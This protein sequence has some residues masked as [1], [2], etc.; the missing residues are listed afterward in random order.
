MSNK[1]VPIKYTSRD[2]TS[3]KQDLLEYAKRYYPETFQ[4]FSEAGFGALMLDTVAY[5]GDILSFYLDYQANESMMDTAIE[6]NNV[7]RHSKNNGFRFKANPS[8]SGIVELYCIVPANS[9]G[10]GPNSDYLPIL[11]QG[12][13]FSSEDGTSFLLMEDI[14]FDSSDAENVVARVNESTG[15][16]TYY[17]IR[18]YGKVISGRF[19]EQRIVVGSYQEFKRIKLTE[20]SLAE[21][22]SVFDS[23]GHEY[24]EVDYLSQNTVY[25]DVI[26]RGNDKDNV[27]N[28]LKPIIVPRRFVVE[29]EGDA[30]YLQFGYGSDSELQDASVAD[31]S[32]VVLQQFGKNYTSDAILDPSKLLSTD[33]FGISPA[34]TTLTITYRV[35]TNSNVN[36]AAASLSTV[37]RPL[38][39]FKDLTKISPGER[40]AVIASF[41]VSNP[42]PITGDVSLPSA[43]EIKRRTLD[44]NATQARAVTSKDYEVMCYAMPSK[45]GAIKRASIVKDIDSFKRNINI[46]V[47]GEDVDGKLS[48]PS[49]ILKNNLKTWLKNIKMI[50]DTI[51]IIDGK[52]INFGIIY[53]VVGSSDVNKF[54]I[55]NDAKEKIANLFRNPTLMG[56]NLSIGQI[57][58]E[59]NN[60]RG[61][62]DVEDVQIVLKTGSNYSTTRFSIEKNKT[63]DRLYILCPQNASFEL[64]FPA[65]DIKGTVR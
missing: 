61:V 23:E 30:F 35:N 39:E 12:T 3:I 11:K 34:N 9:T 58:K 19:V 10:I 59:L 22:V 65:I 6:Y 56:E 38:Y 42:D 31:P 24:Y 41:E 55:N 8:S 37:S 33:K 46:Y 36:I 26:N 63:P 44:Y 51:D 15:V 7:I 45:Y 49:Q 25:K 47:L 20:S 28:I 53:S 13:E 32:E 43:E 29:Q 14:N 16:P 2:F 60:T 27:R 57:F 52:I 21:I 40:Q 64:K 1:K 50:N 54:E 62:I 5:V 4:D 48:I 17:A 18:K